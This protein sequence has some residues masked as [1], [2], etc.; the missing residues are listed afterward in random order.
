MEKHSKMVEQNEA[1][2]REKMD[3]AIKTIQKYVNE[4]RPLSIQRLTEE[5]GLSRSFFYN[6]SEVKLELDRAKELQEGKSFV[7]SK[8][9]IFDKALEKENELLKKHLKEKD[10]LVQSLQKEIEKLKKASKATTIKALKDL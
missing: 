9:V 10:F 5:T 2:N 3:L 6:N 1:K 7:G 4:E 8:K